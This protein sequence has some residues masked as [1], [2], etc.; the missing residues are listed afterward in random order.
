MAEFLDLIETIEQESA[1]V[2]TLFNGDG[3]AV[4]HDT[5]RTARPGYQ[6]SLLEATRLVADVFAGRRPLH[7]LESAMTSSDFPL[8]FGDI[9]DRKLLAAYNEVAPT[10]PQ[11][12]QRGTVRDFR[13]ASRF[14]VDGLESALDEVGERAPYPVD[15]VA[16][17]RDQISVRKLGRRAG[18]SWETF[19]NDDLDAMTTFPD[20]LARAARRTEEREATSI[21]VDTNGPHA[22]LYTG[23][24]GNIVAGNPDLDEEGLEL[25]VQQFLELT[26]EDGEPIDPGNKL[27]LV[28]GPALAV[29]A[30]QIVNAVERRIEIGGGDGMRVV[31]GNGLPFEIV[32]VLNRYVPLIA[33]TNADTS[34]WLFAQ[35]EA[36]P[37]GELAFLRGYE[38][39]QLFRR[40]PNATAVG[41]GLVD[42]TQ[43]DFDSDNIEYK[44]RHVIGSA[45]FTNTGGWRA[46]VASNGT[47]ST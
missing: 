29:A 31:R 19:I 2:R 3:T 8:L 4:R 46:T 22:S 11:Y 30:A 12:I 25:A 28:T 9:L 7:L 35:P 27:V 15:A 37:A 44:V 38:A 13:P 32:P 24:F 17:S 36:R 26:D 39:P 14:A 6:V 20:R 21:F 42:P 41:G 33:Q 5:A 34:W 16:E 18:F 10:W 43:G 47:G 23:G 40:S 45:R 1:D